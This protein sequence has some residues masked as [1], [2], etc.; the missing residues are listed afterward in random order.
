MHGAY[1]PHAVIAFMYIKLHPELCSSNITAYFTLKNRK[2]PKF[3]HF[4]IVR[5]KLIIKYTPETRTEGVIMIHDNGD[6]SG[7][8]ARM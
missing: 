4:A 8:N 7:P 5:D 6:Y 2:R 3:D 1:I